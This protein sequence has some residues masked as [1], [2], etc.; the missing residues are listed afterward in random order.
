MSF[1]WLFV[2]VISGKE[3]TVLHGLKWKRHQREVAFPFCSLKENMHRSWFSCC[4][5]GKTRNRLDILLIIRMYVHR[6][7]K[8]C[9]ETMGCVGTWKD[10]WRWEDK[11]QTNLCSTLQKGLLLWIWSYVAE[12]GRSEG[13][14]EKQLVPSGQNGAAM[15]ELNS[16]LGTRGL[17]V[18]GEQ[19][20][21]VDGLSVS[22][23]VWRV[24]KASGDGEFSRGAVGVAFTRGLASSPVHTG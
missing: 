18:W 10:P 9:Q 22:P 17:R 3:I 6:L 4:N 19:K 1:S 2:S 24:L 8:L 5:C 20:G 16:H 12:E 7:S 13:R 23:A 21:A 11:R 15:V 14:V